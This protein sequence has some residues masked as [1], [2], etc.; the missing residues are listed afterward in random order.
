MAGCHDLCEP[1][2]DG[3]PALFGVDGLNLSY[4]D[5]LE[6]GDHVDDTIDG[7]DDDL[8]GACEELTKSM[9]ANLERDLLSLAAAAE[10]LRPPCSAFGTVMPKMAT[11][12]DMTDAMRHMT[13]SPHKR[14]NEKTEVEPILVEPPS[15]RHRGKQPP[16]LVVR[17]NPKLCQHA[18]C[19]FSRRHPGQPAWCP[20]AELCQ[21]CDP[22]AMAAALQEPG[23]AEVRHTIPTVLLRLI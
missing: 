19:V 2:D 15:K 14:H 9:M 4:F 11:V 20:D 5:E 8:F 17:R 21:W 10:G 7:Y 1:G 12:D 13:V 18:D 6:D 3:V 22:V 16:E 23:Q